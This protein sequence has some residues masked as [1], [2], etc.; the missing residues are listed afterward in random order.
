MLQEGRGVTVAS[1]PVRLN[2]DSGR[3]LCHA[4]IA[5][6]PES[7]VGRTFAHLSDRAELQLLRLMI[8][9]SFVL[10]DL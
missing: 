6:Q 8:D 5:R 10:V 3:V 7:L 2:H 1:G 4:A 9:G